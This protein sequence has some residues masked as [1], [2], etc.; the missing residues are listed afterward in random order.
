MIPA[1]RYR[2]AAPRTG[3]E[4]PQPGVGG[5][6]AGTATQSREGP[7]NPRL[8][9]SRG[10]ATVKGSQPGDL[11]CA[12]TTARELTGPARFPGE[13]WSGLPGG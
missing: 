12:T 13:A 5:G 6:P 2:L 8:C 11:L 3:P 7:A 10:L 4:E 1:G 9:F